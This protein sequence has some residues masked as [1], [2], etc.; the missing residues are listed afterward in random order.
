MQIEIA[1]F[2]ADCGLGD[3]SVS[4]CREL[5]RFCSVRLVTSK[6]LNPLFESLGFEVEKVFRRTRNLPID[7]F[8]FTYGVLRR[9]PD[10]VI[11]QSWLKI[12][13]LECI[14]VHFIRLAGIRCYLTVHDVQP[15]Y[16][17]PW[18]KYV[19]KW[20][21]KSFDGLIAHS[22]HA[23]RVLREMG[24]KFPILVVPHGAYDLF[25]T[26]HLDKA[27]ARSKLGYL[28]EDSFVI[29]FFGRL[30]QR[31]GF[32][33][34]V[35]AT[36]RFSASEQVQFVAAGMC[37]L[38]SRDYESVVAKADGR[39]LIIDARQI[40][41]EEVQYFFAAC[42]AVALPYREGTTSGILKIAMAFG[43]PVIATPVGDL[44]ETVRAPIGVLIDDQDIAAALAEAVVAMKDTKWSCAGAVTNVEYSWPVIANGYFNWL[45]GLRS[46]DCGG[47]G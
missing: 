25:D 39:L 29:L 11:F 24:I 38:S 31:K 27:T 5:A 44:A 17:R 9:R 34:F 41:F 45:S 12:P 1:C 16:P 32:L 42:D 19:L 22:A 3:Y 47:Q 18:S 6:S 43:K 30:D 28:R 21:F 37:G 15:H 13:L 8:R 4:L 36:A 14:L 23:E 35:E 40:P 7:V 2:R 46:A 26:L 20:F 10:A 33:E